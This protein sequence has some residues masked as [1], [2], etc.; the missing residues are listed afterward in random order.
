M[1]KFKF[2]VNGK[3]YEVEVK[4]YEGEN[5]EVIVD[6]TQYNVTV[7]REEEEAPA[8]VA[9]KRQAPKPAAAPKAE[10]THATPADGYK[11]LAPLPGTVMQIYVNVGDVVKRG[12]KLMM[13][14]AMKME[15]N[16]LAEVDGTIKEIK[17]RVGDNILQGAVLF[18]IG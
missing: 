14:E 15:N 2:T 1:K 8:F 6:G 3:E 13:Y 9:P 4:K 18:V 5:A 16:F 7:Q 12:D 10:E 11:S 17:V